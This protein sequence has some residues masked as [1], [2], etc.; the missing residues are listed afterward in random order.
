[1]QI[2]RMVYFAVTQ[3]IL[4]YEITA[5]GGLGIVLEKNKL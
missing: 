3:S 1:M 5:L 4:Q 2:L